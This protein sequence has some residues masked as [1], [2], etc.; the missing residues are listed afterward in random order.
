MT[1]LVLTAVLTTAP[2][3]PMPD[4]I[5]QGAESR[6]AILEQILEHREY[7]DHIRAVWR[8]RRQEAAAAVVSVPEPTTAYFGDMGWAD[9]LRAVGFPESAIPTMLYIIDRESGGD[10]NAVNSS[11]GAC[12]L[13]QLYP[14]PP[15]GL[16]PMTNLRYAYQ[17]Y[18][19]SGFSPWSM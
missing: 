4:G 7:T 6:G 15:G 16:D 13:T 11:S 8:H 9:E 3:L 10:P 1:A 14:C 5:D 19:A 18:L 17:K 2:M 12:G